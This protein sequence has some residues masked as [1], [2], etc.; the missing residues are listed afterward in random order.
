MSRELDLNYLIPPFA[1]PS[2]MPETGWI[3]VDLVA[4][5]TSPLGHSVTRTF[6]ARDLINDDI[7]VGMPELRMQSFFT[8]LRKLLIFT[9]NMGLY[10]SVWYDE[11]LNER[12]VKVRDA[13]ILVLMDDA[14]IWNG[15]Q[16]LESRKAVELFERATD[17]G[18]DRLTF[19]VEWYNSSL[20]QNI[21][22]AREQFRQRVRSYASMKRLRRKREPC[23]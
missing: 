7:S 18:L 12:A 8:E 1:S 22:L 9:Q 3:I 2:H 10:E 11:I 23:S 4:F 14:N 15:E 19:Y 20:S 16:I 17:T 13:E 21:S 6:Q 5:A